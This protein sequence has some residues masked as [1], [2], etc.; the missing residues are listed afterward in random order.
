M[1]E[2]NSPQ[3]NGVGPGGDRRAYFT[4][5]D[6]YGNPMYEWYSAQEDGTADDWEAAEMANIYDWNKSM[7][8]NWYNSPA[9]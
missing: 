1:A 7:F 5:T 4:G 9:Q 8:N 3:M 6:V 2:L